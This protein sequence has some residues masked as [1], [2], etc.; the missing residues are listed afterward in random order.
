VK[1]D[2]YSKTELATCKPLDS[3]FHLLSQ[4]SGVN[5]SMLIV[6]AMGGSRWMKSPTCNCQHLTWIMTHG[7]Y[8][9]WPSARPRSRPKV[10][11]SSTVDISCSLEDPLLMPS[12]PTTGASLRL[13]GIPVQ[14]RKHDCCGEA[15]L[16]FMEADL[17]C[18]SIITF[19]AV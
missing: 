3:G 17:Y 12:L 15:P 9:F 6:C 13:L 19:W 4:S 10:V 14:P 16:A 11:S 18:N 5:G 8:T 7:E 1:F 2:D